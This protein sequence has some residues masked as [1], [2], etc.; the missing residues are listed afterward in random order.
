MTGQ[1]SAAQMNG[2]VSSVASFAEGAGAS[3]EEFCEEVR[4][5]PETAEGVPVPVGAV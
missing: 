4:V 3:F 5:N 2:A 1:Q